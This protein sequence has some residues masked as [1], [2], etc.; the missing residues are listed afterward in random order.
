M[1][2]N[3]PPDDGLPH[4]GFSPELTRDI[5]LALSDYLR[6]SEPAANAEL[7]TLTNRVCAEAKALGLPPEKMLIEIKRLF[8][9]LPSHDV[10][11]TERRQK[12]FERFIT[13]CI[14]SYFGADEPD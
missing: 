1:A 10:P 3:K 5:G 8:E 11:H 6:S 2:D 9:R 13:G 7:Q 4:S 12:T 14:E